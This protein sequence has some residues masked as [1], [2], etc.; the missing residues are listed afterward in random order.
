MKSQLFGQRRQQRGHEGGLS[1]AEFLNLYGGLLD[2]LEP[3]VLELSKAGITLG[4]GHPR[5]VESEV[6]AEFAARVAAFQEKIKETVEKQHMGGFDGNV[7]KI[8]A[9]TYG[10]NSD[11]AMKYGDQEENALCLILP[12]QAKKVS[13][14]KLVAEFLGVQAPPATKTAVTKLLEAARLKIGVAETERKASRETTRPTRRDDEKQSDFLKRLARDAA[15]AK[16]ASFSEVKGAVSWLANWIEGRKPTTKAGDQQSAP[17]P[18][19]DRKTELKETIRELEDRLRGF[20][21]S[22]QTALAS[23]NFAAAQATIGSATETQAEL[24]AA[25]AELETVETGERENDRLKA[26]AMVV[27]TAPPKPGESAPMPGAVH[28]APTQKANVSPDTVEEVVALIT[29]LEKE[30]ELAMD[31]SKRHYAEANVLYVEADALRADGKRWASGK[32]DVEASELEA[33]GLHTKQAAETLKGRIDALQV[34]KARLEAA[35]KPLATPPAPEPKKRV[36]LAGRKPAVVEPV[37][38]TAGAVKQDGNKPVNK[39]FLIK[40][41]KASSGEIGKVAVQN[42]LDRLSGNEDLATITAEFEA[43]TSN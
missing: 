42:F 21:T 36:R 32:K 23:G 35:A 27:A 1:Y 11:V 17:E 15:A 39:I 33:Q 29:R 19:K 22:A 16:D 3:L 9:E 14:I 18:P 43:M 28:P 24:T 6:N 4:S 26:A 20:N 8:V 41:I 5:D 31:S 40:A 34:E 2:D 30:F 7:K 12:G 38:A 25:K 10:P 37:V 13:A